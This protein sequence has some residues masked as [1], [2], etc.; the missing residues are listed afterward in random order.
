MSLLQFVNK[1]SSIIFSKA[2]D[3]VKHNILNNKFNK[4]GLQDVAVS[5]L[6][7]G[8]RLHLR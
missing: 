6:N 2:F 4:H 5:Y 8:E 7:D 1:I 3:T